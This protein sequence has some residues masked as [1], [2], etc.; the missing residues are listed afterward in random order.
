MITA[1]ALMFMLISAYW[2]MLALDYQ[3]QISMYKTW[4]EEIENTPC[5]CDL[6]ADELREALWDTER[7][8]FECRDGE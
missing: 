4:Q 6:A 1:V 3:A 7:M 5:N 2:R 8:L